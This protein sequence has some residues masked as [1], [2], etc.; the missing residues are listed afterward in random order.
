MDKITLQTVKASFEFAA[1]VG[2]II[3]ELGE[4]PNGVLYARIQ[5][6]LPKWNLELH[7][8]LIDLFK[9]M[10]LIQIENDLIKWIDDK[11]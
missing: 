7:N 2:Q 1:T 3:A 4:V 8:S 9:E 5:E 11:K 10:K 6:K